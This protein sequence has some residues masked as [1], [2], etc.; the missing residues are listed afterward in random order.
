MRPLPFSVGRHFGSDL[1]LDSS[2]SSQRH[3]EFFSQEG[4][5][6]LRDLGSTNGTAVN[7]D[8][9]YGECRVQDGDLVHFADAGYRLLMERPASEIMQTQ[10]FSR[11]ERIELTSLA[12]R[13]RAFQEMMQQG[14]L[15][16]HF[17][18]L[19]DLRDHSRFG[20]EV[21][22][23]GEMDGRETPPGDLFFL[24]ENLQLE[25]PLSIAFR[26]KGVELGRG[27]PG[28]PALFVNTHPHEL[29]DHEALLGNLSELRARAP[30]ADLVLEIHEAAV[31]DLAALKALRSGLRKLRIGLAF[32]D[33]GTGQARLLELCEVQPDYL[34]FDVVLV[35]NLHL[36]AK[37]RRDMVENLVRL[38]LGMGISPVAECIETEEEASA[39]A[40]LGF[41]IAQG[42]FFGRPAPVAT[43]L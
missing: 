15:R 35:E 5:L 9:L 38:V 39:C 37:R 27:L 30:D 13:P 10:A 34:K 29:R 16:M 11:T 24:A 21:L 1:R 26:A 7:G 20:F 31:A 22:G 36:A 4:I 18:P 14:N 17:Q 41:E 6:W 40:D 8:R 12:R 19:I 43:F 28:S 42:Y 23:R 33:F 2:H 32:D 3:A 25:I